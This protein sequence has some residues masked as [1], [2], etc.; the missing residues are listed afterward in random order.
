MTEPGRRGLM[1]GFPSF[2]NRF[3]TRETERVSGRKRVR[4]REKKEREKGRPGDPGRQPR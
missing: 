3:G 4:E 1:E 2:V